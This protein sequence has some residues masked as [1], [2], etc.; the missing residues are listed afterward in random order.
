MKFIYFLI[1][2][3]GGL[4]IIVYRERLQRISGNFAFAEKYLGNGGTF[5]FYILLGFGVIIFSFLY[6][7][8]TTEGFIQGT[9]GRFFFT[10]S[11]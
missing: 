3:A 6:V 7:T 10:P 4:A 5:N 1:M 2:L 9:F 8:G 11:N